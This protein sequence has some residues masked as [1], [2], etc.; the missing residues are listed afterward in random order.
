[1]RGKPTCCHSHVIPGRPAL[2]GWGGGP[3][4]SRTAPLGMTKTLTHRGSADLL[5]LKAASPLPG[6]SL[7]GSSKG[8]GIAPAPC[9]HSGQASDL[10]V[11]R[12][13]PVDHLSPVPKTQKHVCRPWWPSAFPMGGSGSVRE[14]RVIGWPPCPLLPIAPVGGG[15]R[16]E[17]ASA[18]RFTSN[19]GHLSL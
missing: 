1:L 5:D 7:G 19:D 2:L 15:K 16:G 13:Q 3:R 12:T 18:P 11:V 6:P 4:P 9:P 17:T 14:V 8:F 10:G